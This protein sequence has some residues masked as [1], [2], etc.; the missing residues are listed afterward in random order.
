MVHLDDERDAVRVLAR[1]M[2]STPNVVATALQ[3]PSMA[4]STMLAGSKYIGLGRTTPLP[5]LDA[6]VH[7]QDRQVAG[8]GQPAV[9]V[10][11]AEAAQHLPATDR[12]PHASVRK[13]GP[14][15]IN[16]SW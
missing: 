15:S 3:P 4:S 16:C 6:L 14:G 12:T 13:S 7:R 8:A 5:M 2:P 1:D 11:L 10:Q 9:A